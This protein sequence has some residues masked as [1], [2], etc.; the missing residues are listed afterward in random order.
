MD[1]P[2]ATPVVCVM[3]PNVPASEMLF[4][5]FAKFGWFQVPTPQKTKSQIPT[6]GAQRQVIHIRTANKIYSARNTAETQRFRP[7]LK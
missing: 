1:V 5:G 2:L 7:I 6:P 3:N 4:P